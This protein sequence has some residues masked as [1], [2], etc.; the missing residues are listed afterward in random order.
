MTPTARTT[1]HSFSMSPGAVP[2]FAAACST[3]RGSS[4]FEAQGDTVVA[5]L[6][7]HTLAYGVGT[8]MVR[9]AL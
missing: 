6:A 4:T 1:C 7:A 5:D 2:S 8:W 9:P 3:S